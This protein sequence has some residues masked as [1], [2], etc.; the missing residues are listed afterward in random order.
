MAGLIEYLTRIDNTLQYKEFNICLNDKEFSLCISDV[1]D[2]MG[3]AF[4]L[5]IRNTLIIHCK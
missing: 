1:A 4:Y 2:H 3:W 5:M